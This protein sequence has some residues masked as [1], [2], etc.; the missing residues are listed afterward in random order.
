MKHSN[1]RQLL[2]LLIVCSFLLRPAAALT[3]TWNA[4]P[5]DG[6]WNLPANWSS[7][8]VPNGP[9]DAA[10]FGL[11]SI[12]NVSLSANTEVDSIIFSAGASAYAITAR[13][14][15]TLRVSG[16]GI[17]NMSG[18]RQDFVAEVDGQGN[19]GT[20]AFTGSASAGTGSNYLAQGSMVR[21]PGFDLPGGTISFR[22]NSS[23]AHGTFTLN[24]GGVPSADG[25]LTVFSNNASAG[26]SVFTA[27]GSGVL[28]AL[29]SRIA[30]H[31]TASA[32]N[33][34]F[35]NNGGSQE[36]YATFE[37]EG[38]VPHFSRGAEMTFRN[39][40]T[41]GEASITNNGGTAALAF[42]SRVS[43][44]DKSI[45]NGATIINNGGEADLAF[46]GST[47]FGGN[48]SAENAIVVNNGG[49]T[50]AADGAR[51][52]FSGSASAGN[53]VL[54]A[55]GG[56]QGGEGGQIY[57]S[58]AAEGGT[59]RVQVF[60]NGSL[61]IASH[62][63]PG[64]TIGS[65]EGSGVVF[66]G[67]NNLSVGGNGESTTYSGLMR[68]GGHPGGPGARDTGGSLTKVGPGTLTI[69][70]SSTY[71]G[72]TTIEAGTLILD[73]SITSA[74]RVNGGILA[75]AG[76][77]RAV[78]VNSGGTLSPGNSPGILSVLGNLTLSLGSTYLVDLN[79]TAVG[80]QYDQASVTGTIIIEDAILSLRIGGPLLAGDQFTILNND[81]TD[82]VT[83]HF[84]GLPKGGTFTA[85]SQ[86]FTISYQGSDGND[87]VLTTVVPEPATWVLLSG[88]IAL[89]VRRLLARKAAAK[90]PLG[91]GT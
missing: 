83:G 50:A 57:F 46:G 2:A 22:D 15:R 7:M 60:G 54:V 55:N 14:T 45:A 71:T 90:T 29:A 25:G 5:A 35:V 28:D 4:N 31:D 52:S 63:R 13:P 42:G 68:D 70:G 30:F 58:L 24:G 49:A 37:D 69:A 32:G 72:A 75:G 65:L 79:G 33:A 41:A 64:V 23:A 61:D 56:S 86:T 87:V 21:S 77:V 76:T 81:G 78:T 53:A 6:D 43:F 40:S 39:D 59:A 85:G 51:T 89:I 17:W 1:L 16:A 9:T 3:G 82:A 73:G 47:G 91:S 26:N 36:A 62:D 66:L 48:S 10:T 88:G 27:H 8:S 12:T 44:I 84:S 19:F 18:L 74:V 34:V 67:G 11:S 38:L 20:I 80:T